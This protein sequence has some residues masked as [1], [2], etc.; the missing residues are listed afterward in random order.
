MIEAGYDRPEAQFGCPIAYTYSREEV[1][2][3]LAEY[4]IFEMEQT[5]IFPYVIEKYKNY[6][7]ELQPW[8]KSMP[9]PM[10]DALER[11]LGWHTLIKCRRTR[12]QE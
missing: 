4:E 9:K 6:E 3:L 12:L 11:K 7:Y 2:S 8:F 10:F 1:V 5:H